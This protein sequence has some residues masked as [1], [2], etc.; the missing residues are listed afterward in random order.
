M[1]RL[2]LPINKIKTTRSPLLCDC[3]KGM[4]EIGTPPPGCLCTWAVGFMPNHLPLPPHIAHDDDDGDGPSRGREPEQGPSQTQA[5]HKS[6][7]IT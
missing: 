6:P 1:G 3:S 2:G 5:R 7:T 4:G